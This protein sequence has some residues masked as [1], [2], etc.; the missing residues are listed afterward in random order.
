MKQPSPKADQL[1]AMREARFAGA[2]ATRPSI[3]KL[4][5]ETVKAT[6]RI[7]ASENRKAGRKKARKNA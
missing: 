6:D 5:D 3:T 1:R 7:R 4:R 2:S